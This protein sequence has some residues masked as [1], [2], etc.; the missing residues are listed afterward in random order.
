MAAEVAFC[1]LRLQI[2]DGYLT[3]NAKGYLRESL[4]I[5]WLF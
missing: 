2:V 5:L 1:G 3:G 4:V